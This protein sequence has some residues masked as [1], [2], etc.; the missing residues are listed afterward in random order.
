MQIRQTKWPNFLGMT[1]KLCATHSFATCLTW[2]LPPHSPA[3]R[4]AHRCISPTTTSLAVSRQVLLLGRTMIR[5][6]LSS[7]R[8][9]LRL[10]LAS[11]F[12]HSACYFIL[13]GTES[14]FVNG[15]SKMKICCLT[16]PYKKRRIKLTQRLYRQTIYD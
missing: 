12:N 10:R 14:F 15:H 2:S 6:A 11:T 16:P 7:L 8:G 4:F 5:A 13:Y 3:G 9:S 1:K